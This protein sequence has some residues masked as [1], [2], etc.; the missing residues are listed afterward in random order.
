MALRK[1]WIKAPERILRAAYAEVNYPNMDE[2]VKSQ[3]QKIVGTARFYAV[4]NEYGAFVGYFIMDIDKI[5]D[6]FQRAHFMPTYFA[7]FNAL[8]F[9]TRDS[10][11]HATVGTYNF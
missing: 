3:L 10:R 6:F 11:Y 5:V 4:E 7:E 2:L 1:I 8:M 9:E